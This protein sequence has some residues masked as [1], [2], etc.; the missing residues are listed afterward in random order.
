MI[1]LCVHDI[2]NFAD[3]KSHVLEMISAVFPAKTI[4][5]FN[6][7]FFSRQKMRRFNVPRGSTSFPANSFPATSS[8]GNGW[9]DHKGL[10]HHSSSYGP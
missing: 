6:V 9:M 7:H 1:L 4:V 10:T 3:P 2:H 8:Q 5:K